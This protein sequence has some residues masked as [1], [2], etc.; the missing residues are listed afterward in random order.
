MIHINGLRFYLEERSSSS[1]SRRRRMHNRIR[2]CYGYP[3][4][5]ILRLSAHPPLFWTKSYIKRVS[6]VSLLSQLLTV[7][8]EETVGEASIRNTQVPWV[9]ILGNWNI[10]SRCVSQVMAGAD[11]ILGHCSLPLVRKALQACNHCNRFSS[12]GQDDSGNRRTLCEESQRK[13]LGNG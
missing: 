3:E 4:R 9:K 5:A 6:K 8:L 12:L 2:C 7:S 13:A 11:S 10:L 1:R